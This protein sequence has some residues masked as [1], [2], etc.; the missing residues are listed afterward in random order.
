MITIIICTRLHVRRP[1]TAE[2]KRR[3][4]NKRERW[5]IVRSKINNFEKRRYVKR[6]FCGPILIL[7][8][9]F[10]QYLNFRTNI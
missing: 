1:L 10:E 3:G 6:A 5:K 2:T 4:K 7:N 8:N 9:P